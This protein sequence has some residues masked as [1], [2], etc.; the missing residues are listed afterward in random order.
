MTTNLFVYRASLKDIFMSGGAALIRLQYTDIRPNRLRWRKGKSM[1][2]GFGVHSLG[3]SI[4][5]GMIHAFMS[6]AHLPT[7]TN[8][9]TCSQ[10]VTY[11]VSPDLCDSCDT[12]WNHISVNKGGLKKVILGR[13]L[14]SRLLFIW[15]KNVC[16]NFYQRTVECIISLTQRQLQTILEK[17]IGP[18][19][20]YQQIMNECLTSSSLLCSP[21]L[22]Q[23][24][25]I[26]STI[27]NLFFIVYIYILFF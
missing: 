4:L 5:N 24:Y 7:H 23:V 22:T 17:G 21:L 20:P 12:Q 25:T 15:N 9:H 13:D 1:Q 6:D 26:D 11:M 2:S 19:V 3:T 16:Y 8:T 10:R 27:P 14:L 18:T